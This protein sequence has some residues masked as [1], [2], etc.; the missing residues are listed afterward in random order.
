MTIRPTHLNEKK[1]M[2][3]D[4]D[5]DIDL[6]DRDDLVKLLP[7]TPASIRDSQGRYSK[8]NTGVYLQRI[9]VFPLEGISRIDYKTAEDQGWF[10]VDLL[11]NSIY[12]GVRDP[13][14]LEELMRREPVWELFEHADVVIQLAHVNNYAD[15]LAA[16]KPRS[17]AELAM[18]IA[19]VRPAK[20]HLIGKTFE[21]MRPE[22]WQKPDHDSY[23]FKKSH[24]TAFAVS[25]IVQLNMLCD[26][27][28]ES[29]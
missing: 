19:M 13:A 8:H 29:A 26:K 25:I 15:L 20:K 27:L 10:K 18:I 14:H 6:A 22:I 1:L 5:V 16:Y 28:S 7:C 2:K 21:E 4:F 11:N 3:I 9:P 23:Y 24:A 12:Q 17:V